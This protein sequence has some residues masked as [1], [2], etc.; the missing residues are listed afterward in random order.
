MSREYCDY[1]IHTLAR[2]WQPQLQLEFIPMII[3]PTTSFVTSLARLSDVDIANAWRLADY[4]TLSR[5]CVL[6]LKYVALQ[7]WLR[8]GVRNY[9][10]DDAQTAELR[11]DYDI[12][13][14]FFNDIDMQRGTTRFSIALGLEQPAT[15]AEMYIAATWGQLQTI[16]GARS[17]GCPWDEMVLAAAASHGHLDTLKYLRQAGCPWN[18]AAFGGAMVSFRS[19]LA[20][21]LTLLWL[22]EHG[23]PLPTAWLEIAADMGRTYVLQWALDHKCLTEMAVRALID[24]QSAPRR[25]TVSTAG[26]EVVLIHEGPYQRDVVDFLTAA[27]QQIAVTKTKEGAASAA[28][29]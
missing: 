12:I 25:Y 9:F 3:F 6:L 13:E 14:K 5:A 16:R 18:D 29:M 2:A 10:F 8:S 7:R 20:I 4:L 23:A 21:K 24:A 1:L 19:S 11:G 28:V 26:D 22:L 17:D 15:T 27:Q